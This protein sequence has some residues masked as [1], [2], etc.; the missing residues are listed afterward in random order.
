MEAMLKK[1]QPQSPLNTAVG[2]QQTHRPT[3]PIQDQHSLDT[4]AKRYTELWTADQFHPYA[5]PSY[6]DVKI[7]CI[8]SK[9]TN[10]APQCS[11]LRI[12]IEDGTHSRPGRWCKQCEETF[13]QNGFDL[14]KFTP[15]FLVQLTSQNL[16]VKNR[17]ELTQR[18]LGLCHKS[19]SIPNLVTDDELSNKI[20]Q[21][22]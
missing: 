15:Q 11:Y 6:L 9:K 4:A 18:L 16:D 19:T 20:L 3:A 1:Y 14:F 8:H 17:M 5:K 2:G 13:I 22:K 21:H 7:I 10:T 12:Y